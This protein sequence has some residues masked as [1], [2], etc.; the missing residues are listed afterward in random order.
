MDATTI[1]TICI[2]FGAVCLITE[3][4]SP[5][6]FMLIPGVVFAVVGIFGFLV[7]GFFES[8]YLIAVVAVAA[9]ATTALTIK[10]YQVLG[11]PAPP[12]TL[13]VESMI[14]RDGTVMV[15]VE[16]GNLRG[17]VRIGTDT[18]SATSESPIDAGSDVTVYAAEG[19]H[20]KVKKKE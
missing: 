6:I 9:V 20:V 17:K 13:V 3:A 8:W 14:G 16:P 11:R 1:A 18:W 5:G 7:D 12:E 15:N 19:V 10:L 4:L 2:I